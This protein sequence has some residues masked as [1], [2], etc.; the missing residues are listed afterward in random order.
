MILIVSSVCS[1]TGSGLGRSCNGTEELTITGVV[2]QPLGVQDIVHRH[3]IVILASDTTPHSSQLLH[4]RNDTQQQP[5]VDTQRPDI[6]ARLARHPKHGQIPL[7]VKLNQL[8]LVDGPHTQLTLDGRDQGRSLE[9][10]AGKGLERPREGL[11]I[12]QLVME[13]SDGNVFLS[14]ALLRLDQPG[15]TVDTHNQTSSDFG[16][17]RARV[18]SLFDTEDT[19]EPGDDFV[20]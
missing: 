1:T 19:L 4:V 18:T 13:S 12:G 5:Q 11:F 7:I 20:R 3:D 16:V 14:C 17:E 8:A 10:S 15:R 2:V 9:E 6:R